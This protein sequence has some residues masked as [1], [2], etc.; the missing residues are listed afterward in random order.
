MPHKLLAFN[1]VSCV[2]HSQNLYIYETT[3]IA[4]GA[5]PIKLFTAVIYEFL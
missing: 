2:P 5:N 4:S 1:D 3:K